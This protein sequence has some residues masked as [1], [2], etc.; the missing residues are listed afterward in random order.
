MKILLDK[1]PD[2]INVENVDGDTPLLVAYNRKIRVWFDTVRGELFKST[3]EDVVFSS[4][5]IVKHS[6]WWNNLCRTFRSFFWTLE[7]P[8]LIAYLISKGA[9]LN[10]RRR[11][12][13]KS[14]L[15]LCAEK[16]KFLD[17]FIQ[18]VLK[19]WHHRSIRLSNIRKGRVRK[20]ADWCQS[21]FKHQIWR[22]MDTVAWVYQHAEFK[23]SK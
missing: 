20:S 19:R 10:A 2:L 23:W 4:I 5:H 21:Q 18:K 13:A 6:K 14:I 7:S 1:K 9:D 15:H 17:I 11:L 16:G 8:E 22:R 3:G 12:Y